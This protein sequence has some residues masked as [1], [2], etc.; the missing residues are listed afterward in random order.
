MRDFIVVIKL[1]ETS[2]CRW[3][4]NFSNKNRRNDEKTSY[5]RPERGINQYLLQVR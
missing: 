5:L 3:E 2:E 1:G 4:R